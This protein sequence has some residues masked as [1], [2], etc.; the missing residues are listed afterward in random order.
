[1]STLPYTVS[2]FE[3]TVEEDVTYA[4]STGF[5]TEAPV[6]N[7][8][9][10]FR[11]IL[12]QGKPK[13]LSLKMDI[14]RPEGDGDASRPLLLMMHGGSFFIGNKR[15]AGQTGWCRYFASL[16]YVAVSIDYRLGFRPT[17]KDVG[18]AEFR[19]LEDAESALAFLLGREDLRID[20]GRIFIAGT[21][22]G[23][24]TAL[25][26]A[27]GM[28]PKF[29]VRAVAN[30]W[31]SVHDLS[32]LERAAV[33]ILSFQSE[34]DP[35]M[36]YGEGYPFPSISLISRL[37]SE[38]MYGTRAVHE[39]ALSL[40]LRAEHHPCPEKRHRLHLDRDGNYT[41]RFYEIRDA[42][43]AFFAGEMQ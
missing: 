2:R 43:A 21:S 20:P 29:P 32:V 16:G 14:Y 6:G 17:R 5:R 35:V 34:R 28:D 7:P 11:L 1:M 12:H 41:S 9:A 22:A 25:H 37:F 36:P 23:A 40:G 42:M 4:V 24:I 31:G 30:L 33:P 13:P 15:E 26:L 38:K 10:T 39:K 8:W 18:A 27:F 3:T 19:A